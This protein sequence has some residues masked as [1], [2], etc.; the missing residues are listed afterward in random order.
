MWRSIGRGARSAACRVRGKRSSRPAPPRC[1]RTSATQA[2]LAAFDGAAVASAG[3]AGV[4]ASSCRCSARAERRG[5]ADRTCP[6]HSLAAAARSVA[7]QG[8]RA[9]VGGEFTD[10]REG[11]NRHT[12]PQC[13][14]HVA[15]CVWPGTTITAISPLLP[16]TKCKTQV[17][18]LG[19]QVG[20]QRPFLQKP[21]RKILSFVVL[22]L[23]KPGSKILSF[24]VSG[25]KESTYLS[26]AFHLLKQRFGVFRG[27][28]HENSGQRGWDGRHEAPPVFCDFWPKMGRSVE[29]T[30]Q[31]KDAETR[32]DAVV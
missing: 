17:N 3:P 28:R 29:T 22:N 13:D 24:P 9:S 6:L 18:L 4:I 8:C 10:R 11:Y 1:E 32:R 14:M 25:G 26:S 21:Q 20:S 5:A 15:L 16:P 7:G 27:F 19:S 31:A 2:H 23:Q 30:P 12:P